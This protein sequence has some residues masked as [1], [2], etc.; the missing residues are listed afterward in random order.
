MVAQHL[1][2]S[3]S[4]VSAEASKYFGGELRYLLLFNQLLFYW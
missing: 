3:S 4:E 2:L 1:N